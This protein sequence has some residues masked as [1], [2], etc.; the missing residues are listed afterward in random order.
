MRRIV[1]TGKLALS[2]IETLLGCQITFELEIAAKLCAE[3][4]LSLAR[5]ATSRV[6]ELLNEG[7]R[8]QL[9]DAL[10]TV[11]VCS[12]LVISS[13]KTNCEFPSADAKKA[14]ESVGARL[15][16]AVKVVIEVV[17]ANPGVNTRDKQ[18]GELWLLM[19]DLGSRLMAMLRSAGDKDKTF[20]VANTKKYA[21]QA[22]A[23]L[24]KADA[25]AAACQDPYLAS[26]LKKDAETLRSIIPEVV[27]T[28]QEVSKGAVPE[29]VLEYKIQEAMQA[30]AAVMQSMADALDGEI[31]SGLD[32]VHA[33]TAKLNQAVQ[34]GDQAL[35]DATAL[36]L[37]KVTQ[38]VCARARLKAEQCSD[39]IKRQALLDAIAAV[40]SMAEHTIASGKAA[41]LHPTPISKA[42]FKAA[43]ANFESTVDKLE[44]CINDSIPLADLLTSLQQQTQQL[45]KEFADCLA[46]GDYKGAAQVAHRLNA[47]IKR[48]ANLLRVEAEQNA[49]NPAYRA[50]LLDMASQLESHM[51]EVFGNA[52]QV[53]SSAKLTGVADP[54]LVKVLNGSIQALHSDV[55]KAVI[56][57]KGKMSELDKRMSLAVVGD[58]RTS[59]A[60][61]LE[62]AEEIGPAPADP[63]K[64][65][66]YNIK[67]EVAKWDASENSIVAKAGNIAEQFAKIADFAKLGDKKG[68]IAAC[69]EVSKDAQDI[70]KKAAEVAASCTDKRLKQ[71]L[72]AIAQSIP[73][74]CTQLRILC[75]VKAGSNNSKDDESTLEQLAT[76][77][78]GLSNAI[79]NTVRASQAASIRSV[80][81]AA[82]VVTAALK[83]KKKIR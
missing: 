63:I 27:K 20:L 66:G 24:K 11:K 79:T 10:E 14:A 43:V 68:L 9:L 22:L 21:E 59:I 74:M 6:P 76:C 40:E 61:E 38:E 19:D 83:W 7:H 71:Q 34:D 13:A 41:L 55:N 82:T 54:E 46:K 5:L 58:H 65:A 33:L 81:S 49:S 18:A 23:L 67:A 3:A 30:I 53:A 80:S 39:P 52:V 47:K 2:T 62:V 16:N 35:F 64:K 51:T 25:V 8:A 45:T 15:S 26:K 29:V 12:T 32:R 70:A 73:T 4:H 60:V 78:N 75:A 57:I 42:H 72:E 28:L 77:A 48:M 36:E 56:A 37:A 31:I 50:Q 17:E 1:A 69:R 44:S